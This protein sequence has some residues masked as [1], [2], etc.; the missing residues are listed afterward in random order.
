MLTEYF[1]G[2]TPQ[3]SIPITAARLPM[4]L[5]PIRHMYVKSLC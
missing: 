4:L 2:K 1:L 3:G 5:A